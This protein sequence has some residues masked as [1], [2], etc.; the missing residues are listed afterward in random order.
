MTQ[1]P[2]RHAAF[3]AVL[4]AGLP[5]FAQEGAKPTR[6][7]LRMYVYP[8]KVHDSAGPAGKR[9]L[10][11]G[12]GFF[13]SAEGDLMTVLHL[14][15]GLHPDASAVVGVDDGDWVFDCPIESITSFSRDLDF[16][17]V[18][19]QLGAA[20]V[21]VPPIAPSASIGEKVFGFVV[22]V[23]GPVGWQ[24]GPQAKAGILS[25]EGR[26]SAVSPGRIDARGRDFLALGSSGAPVFNAAGGVLGIA[27][28]VDAKP[29]A[30]QS[31]WIYVSLPIKRALAYP[32]LAAPLPVAGFLAV[33]RGAASGA[34]SVV[35]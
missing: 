33:L 18:R 3:V 12:G 35:Q 5:A 24:A 17:R 27:Q 1:P 31:E 6:P 22:Q 2:M 14:F 13:L 4:L 8:V 10:H 11:L 21:K 19:V 32:K 15:E 34:R 9:A 16:V 26:I 29:T 30:P 25:T 23:Q 7:D 28:R 20:R